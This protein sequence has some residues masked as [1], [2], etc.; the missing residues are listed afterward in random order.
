MN[1]KNVGLLFGA[2]VG[3]G[4]VWA[5]R[6]GLIEL[7]PRQHRYI[8]LTDVGGTCHVT[9]KPEE[10]LLA[11]NQK[12][13]WHVTNNCAAGYNV[14]LTKWRDEQNNDVTR[15]VADDNG[16]GNKDPGGYVPAGQTL[17]INGKKA[18]AA[19]G[20]LETIKYDVYL[21]GEPAADPI[22]KLVL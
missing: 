15:G 9:T 11:F 10:L 22:V 7:F 18:R 17:P 1:K 12:V 21:N 8:V 5:V 4:L 14:S 19:S 3:A 2:A 6:R 20:L 13:T 16:S